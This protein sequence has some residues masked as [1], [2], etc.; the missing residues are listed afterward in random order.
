M[1]LAL[2][3]PRPHAAWVEAVLS[4]L[5]READAV[6]VDAEPGTRP[7]CDLDLYHV[8]DDPAHAFVFR[9]LRERPGLVLLADWSLR[10]LVRAATGDAALYV[11]EARRSRGDTGVFI[12]RQELAGLGGE[13]LPELL[14]LN[15]RV[16][17]ASLG[18]VAFTGPVR[19]RAAGRLPGRPVVHLPLSF[20]GE[21]GALPDR[22]SARVALG[23]PDASP[24]LALISA[25]GEGP[26]RALAA[27][28]ASEPGLLVRSWPDD[29]AGA[30]RLLAAADVAVAL[31]SPPGRGPA[32]PVVRAVAAGLPTLVSA[33]TVAAEELPDGVAVHVSPGASEAAQLEALL[34]R[35]VRDARLRGR[36]GALARAHAA[37]RQD[38]TPV[39]ARLLDLARL[40]APSARAARDALDATRAGETTPL[41]W[42]RGEVRWAAGE[43][44][45]AALPSSVE[46]LLVALLR[47]PR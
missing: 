46:R 41:G 36:V 27:V 9:A 4:V 1:R 5:R 6:I 21:P 10:R 42:A 44:G 25:P 35:L 40:L 34:R 37:Q 2:W 43:L 12:A 8:A 28:E 22:D 11:A 33:G 29:D 39:A 13:A 14:V 47:A 23:V 3:T 32:A 18:L 19:A 7:P 30:L 38:P 16:L 17:D 31:E 20:L 45:V 26:G 15:E 24:L